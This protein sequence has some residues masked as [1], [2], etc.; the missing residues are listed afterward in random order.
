MWLTCGSALTALAA[1]ETVASGA[2][3]VRD[4][5]PTAIRARPSSHAVGIEILIVVQERVARI[6]A[7]REA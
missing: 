2:V 7:E 4:E 6:L 1:A 3:V 5:Q